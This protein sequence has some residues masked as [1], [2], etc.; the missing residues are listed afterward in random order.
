MPDV[1]NKKMG[2]VI[3][4]QTNAI[5]R[6]EYES[7]PQFYK[8]INT[9]MHVFITSI[10]TILSIISFCVGL[11]SFRRSPFYTISREVKQT[12]MT[13]HDVAQPVSNRFIQ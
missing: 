2:V 7:L 13:T 4:Y 9:S 11:I 5:A 8:N 12:L 3:D 1:I 10:I 6:L